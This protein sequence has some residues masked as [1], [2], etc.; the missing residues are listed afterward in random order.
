MTRPG[1]KWREID[2]Q[3]LFNQSA[4]IFFSLKIM[5]TILSMKK[6]ICKC[7]YRGFACDRSCIYRFPSNRPRLPLRPPRGGGG[8]LDVF[9]Q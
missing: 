1:D 2:S 6:S 3:G 8:V 4:R 9:D 5:F 7:N